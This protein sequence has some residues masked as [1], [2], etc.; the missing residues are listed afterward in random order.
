MESRRRGLPGRSIGAKT[1]DETLTG[2][3][4]IDQSLLTSAPTT[5]FT[6]SEVYAFTRELEELHPDNRHVRDKIRQ[7]LQ[8]L[9]D[10][11]LL[12]HVVRLR[13]ASVFA[14]LPSSLS[15]AAASRRDKSPRQERGCRRMNQEPVS[16]IKR[17]P[18][19][20]LAARICD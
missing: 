17:E 10:A 19:Q 20:G 9:R 6:T 13:F 12:L 11:G 14:L 3:S 5:E 8:V 2:K 16:S 18:R 4:E 1:G 15:Y 7:Q